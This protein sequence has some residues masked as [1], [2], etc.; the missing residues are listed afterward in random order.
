M[1]PRTRTDAVAHTLGRPAS[2]SR[3]KGFARRTDHGVGLFALRPHC[4]PRLI[5]IRRGRRALPAVALRGSRPRERGEPADGKPRAT[6][7][8]RTATRPAPYFHSANPQ[9]SLPLNQGGLGVQALRQ[10]W[11][12]RHVYGFRVP[13]FEVGRSAYQTDVYGLQNLRE[14]AVSPSRFLSCPATQGRK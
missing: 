12:L 5:G 2:T 11:G 9:H 13:P 7:A 3:T 8:T 4:P 10:S 1:P 14:L 6:A